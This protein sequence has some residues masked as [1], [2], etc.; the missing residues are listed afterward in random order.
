[1]TRPHAHADYFSTEMTSKVIIGRHQGC[2]KTSKV[3]I[4]GF[5]VFLK[6]K[7]LFKNLDSS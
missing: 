2:R 7:P 3:Q 5:K 4:L 6:E 1:M